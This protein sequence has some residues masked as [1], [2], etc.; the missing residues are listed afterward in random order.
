[1]EP[2]NDLSPPTGNPFAARH[3]RW[4][5]HWENY[6]ED[7]YVNAEMG[8]E[9]VFGFQGSDPN[10]IGKQQVAACIKHYMGYGVPVSGKDRTPSSITVQDMREKHFAPFLEGIKAGA[11]S[12]MV[13]S[14]MNNGLPFPCQ[15][16]TADRVAERKNSLFFPL[17]HGGGA[18]N[19]FSICIRGEWHSL[20]L[21]T[22]AGQ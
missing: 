17:L 7:C 15:L 16:R 4:P 18:H 1:M 19:S 6:G 11:L 12:V 8:R 5:R 14:A 3:A 9:A 10:H 22:S 20:R 2:G 21:V 13:N